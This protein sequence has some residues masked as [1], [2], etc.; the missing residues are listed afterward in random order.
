VSVVGNRKDREISIAS[1]GGD[2]A[3]GYSWWSLAADVAWWR[4]CVRGNLGLAFSRLKG[5]TI[6]KVRLAADLAV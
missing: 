3:G 5:T 1:N 2:P 4:V 6:E